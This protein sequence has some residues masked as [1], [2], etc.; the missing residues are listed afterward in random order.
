MDKTYRRCMNCM[1]IFEIPLGH[2]NEEKSIFPE[3]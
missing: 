1:E 3:E 2:E